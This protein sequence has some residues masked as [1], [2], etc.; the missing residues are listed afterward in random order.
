MVFGVAAEFASRRTE[1]SFQAWWDGAYRRRIPIGALGAL[2]RAGLLDVDTP[3]D[4]R[5]L[6]VG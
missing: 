1:G 3:M 5:R 2:E 6:R 4:A